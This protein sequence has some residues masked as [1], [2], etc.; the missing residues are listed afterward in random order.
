MLRGTTESMSAAIDGVHS[1]TVLPF[2][3]AYEEPAEFSNRIARN[4][5]IILKEESHFNAIADPAGGSYYVEELTESVKAAA[6]ALFN[7]T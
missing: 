4:V 2:D 7:A 5:Q 1:L 3:S 6:G